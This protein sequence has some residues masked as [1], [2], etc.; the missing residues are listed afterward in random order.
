MKMTYIISIIMLVFF[1]LFLPFTLIV[2]N[3]SGVL[4]NQERV[5]DLLVV[6][7]ISD[8]SLP[9]VIKEITIIET[10][11]GDMDKSFDTRM[12]IS[13]LGGIESEEWVELF[14]IVFPESDRIALVE[15]LLGGM[16]G[17]LENDEPYP[18]V[19]INVGVILGNVEE[20]LLEVTTW[21]FGAFHVPPCEPDQIARYQVGEFGDDPQTLIT[22]TPPEELTETVIS[23]TA[24]VIG[25]A[26]AEEALPAQISLAE[27]TQVSMTPEQMLAQKTQANQARTLLPILW[28]LPVLLFVIAIALAVRSFSDF[29]TWAQWPLFASGTLGVTLALR[30]G[31]PEPLIRNAL[32]PAP[33]AVASPPAV[34]LLLRLANGLFSQVSSAMLWQTLPLLIVGTG[35]LVYSCRQDLKAIPLGLYASIHSLKPPTMEKKA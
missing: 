24:M 10:L 1:A 26:L 16:F 8:E 3:A 28:L 17:W 12:L 6:N 32:L 7:L 22:C 31:N 33:E 4:F 18:D 25:N 14:D 13:V 19:I 29:I 11:H 21:V 30:V 2:A 34:A 15:N 9:R 5:T 27:Q 35:L 23:A 20:N